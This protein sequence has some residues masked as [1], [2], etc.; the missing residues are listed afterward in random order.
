M[1]TVFTLA[2]RITQFVM[3]ILLGL[4]IGLGLFSL[5]HAQT[6][7]PI[8]DNLTFKPGPSVDF[9]PVVVPV[10]VTQLTVV[11]EPFRLKNGKISPQGIL[12]PGTKMTV[13]LEFSRTGGVPPLDPTGGANFDSLDQPETFTVNLPEPTNQARTI[14]GR[15]TMQ[16]GNWKGSASGE[17]Q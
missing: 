9:G 15:I 10:G 1:K 4:F 6:V 16:G 3:L 11:L 17:L 2:E 12:K 14:Q 7:I 5:V 8:A 13:F